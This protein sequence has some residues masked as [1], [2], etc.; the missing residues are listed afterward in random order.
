MTVCYHISGQIGKSFAPCDHDAVA[1]GKHTNCCT[2]G[3]LCL[4]NG[5][6]RSAN[7]TSATNYFWRIGCTDK[8]F[9][10]PACGRYCTQGEQLQVVFATKH[11]ERAKSR[12]GKKIRTGGS[13][14][15]SVLTR[16]NIAAILAFR[17]I[18]K[19]ASARR[20]LHVARIRL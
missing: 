12:S 7:L 19:I 4:S 3:Y 1:A 20:I 2:E 6:C 17:L 18:M 16:R 13:L 9:M 15:G 5:M 14:F 8:T 11:A 10:D